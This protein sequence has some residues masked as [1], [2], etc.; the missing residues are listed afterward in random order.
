M[1]KPAYIHGII[2]TLLVAG[3]CL[4][5]GLMWWVWQQRAY[6]A[7]FDSVRTMLRAL[8]CQVPPGTDAEHWQSAVAW[9]HNAFVETFMY[10]N[11]ADLDGLRRFGHGL[12]ER[13][14]RAP[15][16][17]L[18]EW[19]WDELERSNRYGKRYVER[20]RQDFREELEL[21]KNPRR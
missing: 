21:A 3:A 7:E 18:L 12:E 17:D 15:T 1:N 9:S 10:R 11:L 6:T 16:P 5:F 2:V 20:F 4:G 19:E 8:E 13:M 14:G